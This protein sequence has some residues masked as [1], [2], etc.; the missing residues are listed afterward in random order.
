MRKKLVTSLELSR[1]LQKLGVK[2]E[3]EF[4]WCS[5]SETIGRDWWAILDKGEGEN[6]E[7][8]TFSAFLS[9]ELGERFYWKD[10]EDYQVISSKVHNDTNNDW[11]CEWK[12]LK[13]YASAMETLKKQD[14]TTPMLPYDHAEYGKTEDEAR[15]KML[16]YL[17]KNGLLK[18]LKTKPQLK[19][20]K[21]VRKIADLM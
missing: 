8:E 20:L 9:G 13:V 15:G 18:E 21:K 12:D 14:G 5:P 3:S 17:I 2:Q 10:K 11:F 19:H 4:Y 16:A 7:G 6:W 1:I